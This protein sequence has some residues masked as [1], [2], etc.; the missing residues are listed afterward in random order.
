MKGIVSNEEYI[1]YLKKNGVTIGKGT[2]FFDPKNT[3]VDIQRSWMLTIGNYC[4]ITR[5]C[6]ILQ[7]DYSRSVFRRVYGDIVDGCK[8]TVI[9]DNVFLGMNT[10]VLMGSE[11]GNN[12]IIGAGSV[13]SGRIPDNC[14]AVGNPARVIRTLDEHYAKRKKAYV[15]EAKETAKEF[16]RKYGRK[17]TI[18][19]MGAFFPIYL[20]R[21]IESIRDNNLN[22]SLSGDDTDEVVEAFLFSE[23]LYASYDDFLCEIFGDEHE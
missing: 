10:I 7:H 17:P 3:F 8:K 11:I 6:V 19:D 21:N 9:G 13:V 2:V 20:E 23:K 14:V 16:Y 22:V 15:G 4:K 12:V 18:E 1:D 5:G